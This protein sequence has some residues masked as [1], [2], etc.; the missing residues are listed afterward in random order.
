MCLPA[1]AS[2]TSNSAT[3][4]LSTP[5]GSSLA[6]Q[7]PPS[8]NFESSNHQRVG[9]IKWN[10]CMKFVIIRNAASNVSASALKWSKW[11]LGGTMSDLQSITAVHFLSAI[12]PCKIT[13]KT[14]PHNFLWRFII[15]FVV[16]GI[17][18]GKDCVGDIPALS[19]SPISM[20]TKIYK[21]YRG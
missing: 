15:L 9:A 10:A 19:S 5:F 2:L 18:E 4:N 11:S 1:G 14:N 16:F 20:N 12:C 13:L 6:Q 3:K 7:R 8:G 17:M 21:T